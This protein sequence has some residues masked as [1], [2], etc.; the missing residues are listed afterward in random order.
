MKRVGA[1]SKAKGADFERQ[2]CRDL[3]RWLSAGAAEDWLWRS[4]MSGGRA[5]LAA[6]RGKQSRTQVGDLSSI[7]PSAAAFTS[8]FVVECKRYHDLHIHGLFAVPPCG[9][10]AVFWGRLRDQAHRAGRHPMLVVRQDRAVC[11]VGLD[12]DGMRTLLLKWFNAHFPTENLYLLRWDAFL[13][14]DSPWPTS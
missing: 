6:R 2:V 13:K 3:S 14:Y 4:A 8:Q 1:G 9:E 7:H 5:T 12:Q 11:L 10:L